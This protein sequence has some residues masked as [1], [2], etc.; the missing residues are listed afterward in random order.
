MPIRQEDIN[1]TNDTDYRKFDNHHSGGECSNNKNNNLNTGRQNIE[2]KI[3]LKELVDTFSNLLADKKNTKAQVK[4]FMPN[5][6]VI[7]RRVPH[8]VASTPG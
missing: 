1:Q 2:D 8:I 7:N 6:S 5:A 4:L 3:A